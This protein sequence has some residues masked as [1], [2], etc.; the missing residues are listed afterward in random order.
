MKRLD[1]T[2]SDQKILATVEEWVR[3]LAKDRFSEAYDYLYHEQGDHLTPELVRTLIKNYGWIEP[4]PSGVAFKVTPLEG[5]GRAVLMRFE[6]ERHIG[7]LI[8]DLPL[9]G[10]W[11]DVSAIFDL[12]IV[13]NALVFQLQDIH[14]L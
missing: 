4:H 1:P 11:S 14:V 3:L 6:D 12:L 5:E 10:E 2:A 9:N 8:F 7:H 13:D